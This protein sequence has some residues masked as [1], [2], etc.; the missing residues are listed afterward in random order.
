MRRE[1]GILAIGLIV[2]FATAP[3]AVAQ[4]TD[5]NSPDLILT[6]GKILTMDSAS[7]LAEALAVRG[8]RILAVGSNAA[9][10]ALAG[11][12]TRAIDLAGKSV[13]PGLIDTH[14]HFKAAG[15]ADYVVNM[16]RAKTVTEALEAIKTFAA[17]KKP[18]E[19][20]VGG[21]WHP[22][23][24]LAEKRYLTRQEIDSVAPNIAVC[25]HTVVHFS[26]ANTMALQKAGVDKSTPNPTGGSFEREASG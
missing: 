17:R 10:R 13:T 8:D 5:A 23:S 20:I 2:G 4:Q 26:I 25:L 6:N 21:S 14:A 18:G 9:V 7:T 15:L 1:V 16:S 3:W 12:Q 11:P 24:Q 22:P 19:W